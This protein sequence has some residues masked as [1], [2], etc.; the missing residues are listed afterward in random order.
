MPARITDARG[1]SLGI[2][3]DRSSTAFELGEVGEIVAW[4]AARGIPRVVLPAG[5]FEGDEPITWS[6]TSG[7]TIEGA[8]D[9][10]FPGVE[11]DVGQTRIIQTDPT[12]PAIVLD[13]IRGVTL[14]GLDIEGQGVDANTIGAAG[15]ALVTQEWV[16][17]GVTRDHSGVVVKGGSS[18]PRVVG[19]S[20]RKFYYPIDIGPT[21]TS[22]DAEG[23][24]RDCH[25]SGGLAGVT[26]GHTQTKAW[27]FDNVHMIGL[28]DGFVS[29]DINADWGADV[30]II[31]GSMHFVHR[32]FDVA[33]R[34]QGINCTGMFFESVNALGIFG[35]GANTGMCSADFTGISFNGWETDAED[36]ANHLA[37]WGNVN[38]HGGTLIWHRNPSTGSRM[39]IGTNNRAAVNFFGTSF[40]DERK[41][42][43]A[44]AP[45]VDNSAL[46]AV[47]EVNYFKVNYRDQDSATGRTIYSS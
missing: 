9:A 40:S 25:L 47:G 21:G 3:S 13:G 42:G 46:G 44:D 17:A 20:V 30:N 28:R 37:A 29:H 1:R 4:A 5:R 36:I 34:S 33:L 26:M 7:I 35:Q 45:P 8:N 19:C 43:S 32:A 11:A 38:F 41:T 14:K 2:V 15:S 18:F 22:N 31:G 27:T 39:R 23:I 10:D 16:P 12:Q 6:G 24:V